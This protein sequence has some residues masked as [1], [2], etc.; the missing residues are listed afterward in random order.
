M[1]VRIRYGRL[2]TE[3]GHEFGPICDDDIEAEELLNFIDRK[4]GRKATLVS[5]DDLCQA[6][7]E[8]RVSKVPK[9]F[10]TLEMGLRDI[11]KTHPDV[12]KAREAYDKT[13]DQILKKH[14]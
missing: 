14:S 11:E 7:D 2:C 6:L 10:Q 12:K 13:R 4:F 3:S 9:K 5:N 1:N 8:L